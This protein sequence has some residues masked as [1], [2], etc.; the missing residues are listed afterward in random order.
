MHLRSVGRLQEN[1]LLFL[2]VSTWK[3]VLRRDRARTCWC[4]DP[5][6]QTLGTIAKAMT[7]SLLWLANTSSLSVSDTSKSMDRSSEGIGSTQ[8]SSQM[9]KHQ[10]QLYMQLS[11]CSWALSLKVAITKK[12]WI[13]YYAEV[14]ARTTPTYCWM[15]T[16]F[17][18][19]SYF[20]LPC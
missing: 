3:I 9:R 4:H 17:H 1:R 11:D 18:F 8:A 7:S 16:F 15:A 19:S 6:H 20:D 13:T 12:Q 10:D 2:C 5:T 14:N